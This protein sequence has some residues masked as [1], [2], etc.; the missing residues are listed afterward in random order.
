MDLFNFFFPEAAQASH[1]RRI[2][3]RR[4]ITSRPAVSS[5]Q[6]SEIRALRDD[7]QFLTLVMTRIGTCGP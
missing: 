6:S 2:A 7:V 4:P 3:N 1:L 5:E